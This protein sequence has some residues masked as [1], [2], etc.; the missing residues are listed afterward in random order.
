MQEFVNS[1]SGQK[2][3]LNNPND[4]KQIRIRLLRM[5]S[6]KAKA[7]I[8][9][10]AQKYQAKFARPLRVTSLVRSIDYQ[11]G[12]SVSNANALFLFFQVR[13]DYHDPI[14]RH[15]KRFV[16]KNSYRLCQLRFCV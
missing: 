3:D 13:F 10:I 1:L 12:L 15:S 4:R 2:Y 14:E 11:I 8:E 5:I 6:P 7:V 9:E 16:P